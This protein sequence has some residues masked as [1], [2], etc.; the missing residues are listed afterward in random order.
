MYLF[1]TIV[2]LSTVSI[3]LCI[4]L[5]ATANE[6]PEPDPC[7]GKLRVGV[8]VSAPM[9]MRDSSGPYYGIAIDLWEKVA[10]AKH[11]DYCYVETPTLSALFPSLGNTTDVLVGGLTATSHR[12]RTYGNFTVP[13][14]TTGLR[15][16]AK[17]VRDTTLNSVL[18]TLWSPL[19]Q[20]TLLVVCIYIGV[21]TYI[22]WRLEC[23]TNKDVGRFF[24]Y[25]GMLDAAQLV[26]GFMTTWGDKRKNPEHRITNLLFMPLGFV[27]GV[28]FATMFASQ[29]ISAVIVD[30][31]QSDVTSVYDLRGKRVAAKDGSAVLPALER[32][33]LGV[34]LVA[35]P[36]LLD[37]IQ[38]AVEN[39]VDA[40]VYDELLLEYEQQH[41]PPNGLALVGP[42]FERQHYGFMVRSDRPALT[43]DINQAIL[44]LQE[45]GSIS[46]T[47]NEYTGKAPF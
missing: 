34:T 15:I 3:L 18:A 16:L 32:R 12:E 40:V 17:A 30:D 47:I 4:S 13:F 2:W 5:T 21:S 39:T 11:L 44:T 8:T 29:F 37:A 27:M 24:W 38:M 31:L 42:L 46:R 43:E 19:T 10:S 36:T 20:A 25:H 33:D 28:L 35:T 1:K 7:E 45:S 26:V 9:V 23:K 41:M 6:A 22:V 14:L